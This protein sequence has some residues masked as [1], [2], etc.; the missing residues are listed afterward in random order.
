MCL[1]D[2][3]LP[4]HGAVVFLPCFFKNNHS[5]VIGGS[6]LLVGNIQ[7]KLLLHPLSIGSWN[8][9]HGLLTEVN[10]YSLE[11]FGL[12]Y[13]CFGC[14]VAGRTCMCVHEQIDEG[15]VQIGILYPNVHCQLLGLPI[16]PILMVTMVSNLWFA[17][18]SSLD[19]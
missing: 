5:V 3:C 13:L 6:L 9:H 14:G 16:E 10:G 12:V 8:S 19:T 7:M 15:E 18:Q 2:C 1:M 17:G 4:V 11:S